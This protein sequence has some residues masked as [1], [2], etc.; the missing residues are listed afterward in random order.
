MAVELPN[1]FPAANRSAAAAAPVPEHEERRLSALYALDILD[2]AT[3][4]AYDDLAALAAALFD[5]PIALITLVDEHRQWFKA[6]IGLDVTETPREH[7]F[8]AHAIAIP[9]DVL[10]VPDALRDLRFAENPLVTGD[11]HIRF[12]AGAPLL[13]KDGDALG[14]LCIIDRSPRAPSEHDL[15][16]LRR[17]AQQATS[18]LTLRRTLHQVSDAI[19]RERILE[20]QVLDIKA[21][22][23]RRIAAE[24]HEGVGQRLTG[25]SMTV[26]ALARMA[27]ATSEPLGT[28]LDG[29]T[30]QLRLAI[31]ECRTIAGHSSDFVIDANGFPGALRTLTVD[32]RFGN[33]TVVSLIGDLPPNGVL[34]TF[35][36]RQLFLI[37]QEA[38]TNARRHSGARNVTIE[39]TLKKGTW[40]LIVADDGRGISTAEIETAG[41][42]LGVM[43]YR[44][45]LINAQLSIEKGMLGIGATVRCEFPPVQLSI[46]R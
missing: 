45:N 13:S 14:T 4:A 5:A 1:S 27:Q 29:V 21:A 35:R 28:K 23:G 9:G 2:S 38:V 30:E 46:P 31:S 36:A 6:N 33:D 12:Y 41:L 3:E 26:A 7:A 44:A 42:G 32:S 19:R 17:L 24:I 22:E 8:C 11:P 20:R 34:D 18:Q 39:C 25:I 10:V 43:R 16:L 37:A 15:A 40:C